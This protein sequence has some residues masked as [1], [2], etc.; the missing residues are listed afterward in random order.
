MNLFVVLFL[1]FNASTKVQFMS[2]DEIAHFAPM[3]RV[4]RFTRLSSPK[5]GQK[6]G[7]H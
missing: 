1:E 7:R 3:P 2:N 5:A 4:F 6:T